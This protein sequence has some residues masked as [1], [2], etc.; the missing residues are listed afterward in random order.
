MQT[1]QPKNDETFMPIT[2]GILSIIAGAID[3]LIGTGALY[4]AEFVHRFMFH[5]GLVGVGIIAL[6]LGIV[7][8]VGG[9]F[10]L[11]RRIWGLSLAGAI[12]ALFPP[13]IAILGI[14]AI[15]FVSLSKKEFGKQENKPSEN[16]TPSSGTP[17][18]SK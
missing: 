13:H 6:I 7:A 5:W 9:V 2:A 8:I 4:R 17:S 10:A 15:I 14:L 12:C 11:K 16:A 3:F 18:A 1:S